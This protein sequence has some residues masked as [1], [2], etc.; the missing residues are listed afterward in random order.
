VY[1][2]QYTNQY[3]S[4]ATTYWAIPYGNLADAW[5]Y[6]RE[7]TPAGATI[8]YAN[9]YFVHPLLGTDL[10]H[11]I[12]YAPTRRGVKTIAGLGRIDGSV[13]GEQIVERVRGL[14]LLGPDRAVWLANLRESGAQYLFIAKPGSGGANPPELDFA[15]H[16]PEF[17]EVYDNSSAAIFRIEPGN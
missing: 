5:K 8:A 14:T 10:N 4:E 2:I 15:R 13:T 1:W 11:R 17:R 9:T 6:A 12:A 7:E 3:R 16:S